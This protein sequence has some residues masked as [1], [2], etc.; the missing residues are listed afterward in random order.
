MKYVLEM[1]YQRYLE[2]VLYADTD[3]SNATVRHR[4]PY[5]IFSDDELAKRIKI[6]TVLRTSG[7]IVFTYALTN[8]FPNL[9]EDNYLP[10][11][12]LPA[13]VTCLNGYLETEFTGDWLKKK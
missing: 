3:H 4:N 8:I 9:R 11:I 13:Q 1:A 12:G 6:N 5:H 10:K 2:E 7:N